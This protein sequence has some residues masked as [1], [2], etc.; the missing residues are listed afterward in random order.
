MPDADLFFC[1][2]AFRP[3]TDGSGDQL[4][5]ALLA[6]RSVFLAQKTMFDRVLHWTI[7]FACRAFALVVSRRDRDL[8]HAVALVCEQVVGFLD[9]VELEAVGHQGSQVD[10]AGC[11]DI[12]QAGH[13]LL[14]AGT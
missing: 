8:E 4:L 7:L 12:H 14:A 11:D 6:R 10:A 1:R 5:D 13:A 2:F 9:V 3:R